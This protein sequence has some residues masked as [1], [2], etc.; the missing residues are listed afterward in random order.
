MKYCYFV[1]TLILLSACIRQKTDHAYEPVSASIPGTY[2]ALENG[3]FC[4]TSDTLTINHYSQ[5]DNTFEIDQ[6]VTFQRKWYSLAFDPESE[7]NQ[8]TSVL[9]Y[10]SKTL[11]AINGYPNIQYLSDQHALLVSGVLYKKIYN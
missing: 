2:V 9:D 5:Y 6:R 10:Q 4:L 11:N 1:A 8:W 3:Q 7:W